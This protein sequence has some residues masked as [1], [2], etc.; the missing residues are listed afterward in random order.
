MP[1]ITPS[2]VPTKSP[3][4][5]FSNLTGGD[6]TLNIRWLTAA[7][8][9][10]YE[11]LNR[12]IVDVALRQLVLAKAVDALQLAIGKENLFPF[13]TQPQI[14][15]GMAVE[16]IPTKWIWDFHASMPKKWENLRLAKIKRVAGTNNATGG[17]DGSLRLIFS[18]NIEG[19]NT[20]VS[21]FHAD[22]LI[23]SDLTYQK[24]RLNVVSSLEES[25][26]ISLSESETVSGFAIFR[27]LDISD[28]LILEFLDLL[29]P[30]IDN[31]DTN[32]DGYYDSPSV[33]EI[34][35]SVSGGSAVTDDFS[36]QAIS[37]GT[38]LLTS[39]SWNTIP[40][41]DSDI[42]SWL[43]SFNYPFDVN[44]NRTSTDSIVIPAG[45]FREFN[46]TA[47]AGDNPTGNSSGTYYPV[48][49][50]RIERIGV[51]ADRL[52]FYFSTYNVTDTAPSTAP[53]EFA[54]LDLLR[55]YSES[56]VV[57][58]IPITN[59]Q[60][61]TGSSANDFGQHFGRG[62]VVL[63][64]IWTVTDDVTDMFDA[65][66]SIIDSP[67]D[68]EFS[69]SATRISSF[70]ISRIPKYTPTV[71]QSRAMLGSS[72]RLS[73]PKFPSD[74]NRFVTE[75][76]QGLGNQVD[77]EALP[78]IS[79]NTSIDRY[80]FSGSLAHKTVKLVVRADGLGDN[81]A[82]YENDVL[83]RLRALLGRDPIFSDEWYNGTRFMK[84]NGDS[85]QG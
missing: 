27:T 28:P 47:P 53:I 5:L 40:Q 85:W 43:T 36:L 22:Y 12:P 44:A 45:I 70:G 78:G 81:P 60:L 25:T 2:K 20:E 10:F 65:F 76:D 77:L 8:P 46:I 58:I 68:T 56:D 30:P 84:Y 26:P 67:A 71:G 66:T 54:T 9:A 63:S 74:T 49:I 50:S 18:A 29:A 72:A 24:V 37:H 79:P 11:A 42:Q 1:T 57:E 6:N 38:G 62:H 31:S 14:A 16:E 32:S 13:L 59:L 83:P 21:I 33:Y 73:V 52:K 64:N 15:S 51:G 39:S 19:S 82:T 17:Y 7:D 3:G 41:L 48:W 35:D 75:G 23:D 61:V 34:V 4:T 69:Q 80:G 55:S